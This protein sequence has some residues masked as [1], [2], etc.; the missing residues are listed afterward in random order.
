MNFDEL[1]KEAIEKKEVLA[2]LK[3]EKG[4]EVEVS[5]FTSD[6][7]PTDINAV[8]VNC[9]YKQLENIKGIDK[10]FNES[11]YKLLEGNA[12]EI[13]IAILYF[14]ACIFQEERGKATFK[15][16][17]EILADKIRDRVSCQEQEL[18]GEIAF[19]NGMRKKNP[20]KNIQNF[21]NYYLKKYGVTILS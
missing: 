6:V 18:K 4:Y 15:I 1:I 20:W 17:K 5:R 19:Y 10:I 11:F 13:Y 14:D 21:N 7:F 9:F 12:V 3:G 8:L 16:E 2:L